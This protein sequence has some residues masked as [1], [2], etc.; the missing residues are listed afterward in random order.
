[1]SL[2][3]GLSKMEG[4]VFRIGHLGDFNDLMLMGALSGVEMGLTR[5]RAAPR[6][7]RRSRHGL[8]EQR[9]Q[10]NVGSSRWPGTEFG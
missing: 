5:R 9:S 2:G 10:R 7:R 3:A 8:R 4:K 1:M 6:R